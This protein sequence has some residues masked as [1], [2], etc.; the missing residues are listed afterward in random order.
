MQT[1]YVMT[2]KG[3]FRTAY[4]TQNQC[5][6]EG[7]RQYTYHLRFVFDG[8]AK[9]DENSFLIDHADID[10]AIQGLELAGSCEE[11][12]KQ[13]SKKLVPMLERKKLPLLACKCTIYPEQY[14]VAFLE[15]ITLKAPEYAPC[16]SL[17]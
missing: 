4:Y 2:R 12:H 11:M 8:S 13:I 10:R 7:H 6:V 5:K 16:L 3:Q 1:F 14:A 17:T 15:F 9:L